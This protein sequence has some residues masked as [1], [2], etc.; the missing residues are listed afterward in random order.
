MARLTTGGMVRPAMLLAALLCMRLV[1]VSAAENIV[2]GLNDLVILDPGKHERGL[3]AVE[4]TPRKNAEGVE[5]GLAIDI[6]PKVHVHR[7][8]Y[9]GDKIYQGPII[10]GG[11]TVVVANHPQTGERMYVDV[12]L[13]AGA[14]RIAYTRHGISY[15]YSDQRVEVTF[16]HFPFDPTVAVV[17]HHHGKGWGRKIDD[18]RQ[19]LG[20]HVKEG[21]ENAPLFQSVKE[22]TGET[23]DFLHGVKVSLGDLSTQS[24]DGLKTLTNMVPGIT[25]LKSLAEQ[26]PEKDYAN[27]IREAGIKKERTETPFLPTNR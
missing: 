15:I 9:S 17:K 2:A 11:P 12:V 7:Y 13:P 10:Q 25:Y 19:H 8:Y 18:A 5:E 22:A 26:E 20:Q 21:L 3:P 6:P 14:P 27:S 4:L 1:P 24:V 16:R 23:S